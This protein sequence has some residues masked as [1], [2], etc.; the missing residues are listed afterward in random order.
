MESNFFSYNSSDFSMAKKLSIT[1][2]SRQLPFL[3]M[4]CLTPFLFSS[5]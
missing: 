4:L 2:L 5:L 3:D 1:L